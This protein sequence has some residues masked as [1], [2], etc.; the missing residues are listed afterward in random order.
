MDKRTVIENYDLVV[1]GVTGDDS[2]NADKYSRLRW[3]NS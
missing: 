3:T 1:C 2:T